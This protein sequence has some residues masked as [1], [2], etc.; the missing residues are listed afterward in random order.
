MQQR[1]QAGRQEPR[2]LPRRLDPVGLPGPRRLRPTADAE[3]KAAGGR[4]AG[5]RG[6]EASGA[7]AGPATRPSATGPARPSSAPPGSSSPEAEREA[8]LAAVKAENPGLSRWKKM[9]EPLCL[10]ALEKRLG[11]AKVAA[12][13]VTVAAQKSLFP[14]TDTGS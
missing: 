14:E 4:A 13:A 7:A 11:T 1:G 12:G 3:A 9:L 6:A 2:R 10:A 8:I 5:R